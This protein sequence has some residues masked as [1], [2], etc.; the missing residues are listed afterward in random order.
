MTLTGILHS[1]VTSIDPSYESLLILFFYEFQILIS[2]RYLYDGENVQISCK[3]VIS[4]LIRYLACSLVTGIYIKGKDL[5][6]KNVFRRSQTV[7]P[8]KRGEKKEDMR[9]EKKEK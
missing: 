7:P 9:L 2:L 3:S 5:L 8:E 1:R 4:K 6:N